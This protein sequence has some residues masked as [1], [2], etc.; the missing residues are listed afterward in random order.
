M[1]RAG[2]VVYFTAVYIPCYPAG[3]RRII[4]KIRMGRRIGI[5][6]SCDGSAAYF[7]NI[8]CVSRYTAGIRLKIRVSRD[9]SR[10]GTTAYFAA[11][12]IPCYPSGI[13]LI[14]GRIGNNT[15]SA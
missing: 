10:T 4:F 3:I 6:I 2:T 11:V 1:S 12:Y 9:A 15:P 13:S 14:P 5:N 7:T 8:C